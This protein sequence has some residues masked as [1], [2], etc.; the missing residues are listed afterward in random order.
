MA[1]HG[2]LKR[3]PYTLKASP[4]PVNRGCVGASSSWFGGATC[5]SGRLRTMALDAIHSPI[6]NALFPSACRTQA[7]LRARKRETRFSYL[8]ISVDPESARPGAATRDR[9]L[10]HA[11]QFD[12]SSP[13]PYNQA[14]SGSSRALKLSGGMDRPKRSESGTVQTCQCGDALSRRVE[15]NV[16]LGSGAD[17]PAG[18]A[19]SALHEW[20]GFHNLLP[21]PVSDLCLRFFLFFPRF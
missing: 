8:P 15:W 20:I 4:F 21:E 7:K 1:S 13:E 18:Q 5:A 10:L 9:R 2:L 11:L 19:E 6:E 14:C 16:Q 3:L 17:R 12:P